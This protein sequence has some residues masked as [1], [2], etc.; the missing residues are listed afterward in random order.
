MHLAV[1]V[2]FVILV[3]AFVDV[4]GLPGEHAEA[5][6][7]VIFILTFIRVAILHVDLLTPAA[8]AELHTVLEV[9]HIVTPVFP[10]ILAEAVRLPSLV[11]P[12]IDVAVGEDVSS[13]AVFEAVCP[14]AFI[15]VAVFPLMDPVAI[16]LARSPLTDIRVAEDALP[17]ALALLQPR[18]PL[19]LVHFP[20]RPRVQP[21]AVWLIVGELAFIFVA[22]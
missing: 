6:F 22:I 5:V 20:V 3:A 8:L 21:F 17:Y 12:S 16:S 1:A 9:T 4:A 7:L 15:P 18:T 2:P 11:L 13:L 19:A 10:L 14:L